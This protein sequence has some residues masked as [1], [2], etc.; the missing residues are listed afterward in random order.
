[1]KNYIITGGAGFI[2]SAL[3][4][5]LVSQNYQ[6]FI[7]DDLSTGYE[8]NVPAGAVFHQID[9]SDAGR[10]SNLRLPAKIDVIFHLAAQPSSEVSFDDP[11]RDIDVNYKATYNILK[12]AEKVNCERFIYVSSMSVYGDA[13]SPEQAI[14]EDYPCNPVSYY[15]ANKLASEKMIKVFVKTAKMKETILRLFNVYG[16][17]Q[18]MA[19]M[20]Q[21]MVSIYLSYLMQGQPINVKGALKRYRD[22][23][24][25]DDVVDVFIACQDCKGAFGE[26]FNLG[27]GV[28]TTVEG[29]LKA[30]LRAYGK[31]DFA[32]WVYVQ[33]STKGD[34][35]GFISDISKIKRALD[36]APRRSLR[37]G[38]SEMKTWVDKNEDLFKNKVLLR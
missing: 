12:L 6:V 16:P 21:G 2:G 34:I 3:A 13:H 22:F 20:R 28:K 5:R 35:K 33:G 14:T 11:G 17:G 38:I 31:E 10:L 19:N 8:W 18:N 37:E 26:V 24:Y 29:L 9:V 36:W 30:I 1:M 32:K 4:R 7:L 27:S 23:I 15:G 25:I